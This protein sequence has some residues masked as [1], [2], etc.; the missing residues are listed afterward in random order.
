MKMRT[1]TVSSTRYLH[2]LRLELQ[3]TDGTVREL[4]FRP[5]LE[6]QEIPEYR[7][8]LDPE[9]FKQFRLEAGNVVWG[10]DWDLVWLVWKLY[11]GVV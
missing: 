9:K 6:R 4:D 11:E 7:A 5:A 3:F 1:L 2:D 10:D 8:Y